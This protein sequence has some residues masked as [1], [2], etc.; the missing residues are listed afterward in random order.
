MNT[1]K[2]AERLAEVMRE[3]GLRQV[4]V[5]NLCKPYCKKYG[6]TLNKS[7]LSQ[8]LS[9]K[10]SQKQ[11]KLSILEMALGVSESWLMGYQ[12]EAYKDLPLPT[13][14]RSLSPDE[15]EIIEFYRDLNDRGKEMVIEFIRMASNND[16]YKKR[17]RHYMVE[18]A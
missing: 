16:E 12:T 4:D 14:Q 1:T 10:F 13:K 9:G 8:Y 2:T 18:D 17:D 11:D 5:L 15:L 6:V 3:R 7:H